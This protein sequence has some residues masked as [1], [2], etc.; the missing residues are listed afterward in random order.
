MIDGIIILN[1]ISVLYYGTILSFSF[2]N[3]SFKQEKLKYLFC[4]FILGALQLFSSFIFTNDFIVKC[5]PLLIHF[6]LFFMLVK[7]FK[8]DV[9]ISAIAVFTAYLFC[10]PRQWLGI[11]VSYFFDHSVL[12]S[13]LTELIVTIP[14]LLIS[15]FYLSPQIAQLKYQN[16]MTLKILLISLALYYLYSYFFTVYTDLLYTGGP[17]IVQIPETTTMIF[18]IIFII[19]Y[20][21]ETSIRSQLENEKTI[22]TLQL[23]S[24]KEQIDQLHQLEKQRALHRHDL[25]HH[26]NFLNTCINHK[27]FDDARSYIKNLSEKIETSVSIRYTENEFLNLIL[28]SYMNKAKTKDIS[29]KI[30]IKITQLDR[31]LDIEI[32]SLMSNAFTNAIKASEHSEKKYIVLNIFEKNNKFCLNMSNSCNEEIIFEEGIPI[33]QRSG[34]GFGVTSMINIIEKYHGVYRFSVKDDEFNFQLSM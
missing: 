2:A 33:S 18:Y 34:H 26:L 16:K 24:A 10:T 8:K 17:V 14:L 31:F 12:S 25:I 22:V 13:E 28:I 21:K 7:Y 4:C 27:K 1:Y 29:V 15:I 30:N 23:T 5:Y 19:Y 6:P 32:C 11:G 20:M 9:Y 3:I